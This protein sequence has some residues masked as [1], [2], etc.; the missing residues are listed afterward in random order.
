[1]DNSAT[2]HNQPAR[3]AGIVGIVGGLFGAFFA[4]YEL[5][6]LPYEVSIVANT[7]SALTEL[8]ALVGLAGMAM[9]GAAGPAWWGRAGIGAAMLGL[10]LLIC[11][12]FVEPFDAASGEAFFTIAPVVIGSGMLATGVAVLRTHRWSGWRRFIPVSVGAFVFVVYLPVAIAFPTDTGLWSVL[13]LWNLIL[14]TLGLAV[15]TEATAPR[16]SRTRARTD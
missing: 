11:G 6:T 7:R 16:D 15:L 2:S 9:L 3:V 4:A 8:A 12:E 13:G 5:V 10:L 14:A 1:M